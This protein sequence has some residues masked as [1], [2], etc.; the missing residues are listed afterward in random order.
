M[1]TCT[2]I[3]KI[4]QGS[5]LNG[6]QSKD[7]FDNVKPLN[8]KPSAN[9]EGL[10]IAKTSDSL[11]A[12][13][14]DGE[15]NN[16]IIAD[17]PNLYKQTGASVSNIPYNFR[18]IPDEFL[19]DDFIDDPI[20]MRFIRWMFK[21]ISVKPSSVP[22]KHRKMV[23]ELEPFE[24]MYGRSKC[25]EQA[26]ISLKQAESRLGQLVG[27][28]MVIKVGSKSGSTFSVYRLVTTS[29]TQNNG[30]QVG[31]QVGQH[32]G[33][34]VGHNQE[35]R[36]KKK[37]IDK[38][39]HPSIPSFEKKGK[40]NGRIDDF[41]SKENKK[42]KIHIFT[43][44]YRNDM[45]F[46]VW[47]TEEELE[48]CMKFHGNKEKIIWQIQQI[49]ASPKRKV[50]ISDWA[51]AI[52]KWKFVNETV[53]RSE[54]NEQIGKQLERK[55]E[56]GQGWI[57]TSHRDPNKDCKGL[58]FQNSTGYGTSIYIL[59]TDSDFERK[60]QETIKAKHVKAKGEK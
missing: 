37:D 1:S 22:I 14:K 43:G 49:A 27:Q 48:S 21:R 39:D 60:V 38:K 55:Y 28:H 17:P 33:Q 36:D 52:K 3:S 12:N 41:S 47:L 45:P 58:L 5:L 2:L 56:G 18:P 51:N 42:G 19:T 40:R 31:Q 30:Q 46:E 9:A 29:F 6:L 7:N 59:Y 25:A 50:E 44:K 26:G 16:P 20:M 11:R 53:D 10:S 8:G 35:I 32:I 24:F 23:L 34:Q 54:Q 15:L 4:E 57:V 13:A